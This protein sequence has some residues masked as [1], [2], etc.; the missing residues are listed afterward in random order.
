[1]F[2]LHD[3]DADLFSRVEISLVLEMEG[4]ADV[5]FGLTD[6]YRNTY[7]KFQTY[8]WTPYPYDYA[9]DRVVVP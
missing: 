7:C 1:M 6:N 3:N 8:Q 4:G 9:N 5:S 2:Q